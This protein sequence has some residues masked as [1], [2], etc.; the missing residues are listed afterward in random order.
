MTDDNSKFGDEGR[1]ELNVL[2]DA[3]Q[4]IVPKQKDDVAKRICSFC[5]RDRSEVNH[6]IQGPFA[7]ICDVCVA[8]C[9]RMIVEDA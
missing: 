3:A 9:N 6:M 5:G 2:R 8:K 1:R 4:K 7:N